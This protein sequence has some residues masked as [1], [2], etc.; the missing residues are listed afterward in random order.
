MSY[1]NYA[2]YA[3]T[4][5]AEFIK[6]MCS[7]EFQSLVDILDK[8]NVSLISFAEAVERDDFIGELT[9]SD[10]IEDEQVQE[11]LTLWESLVARFKIVTGGLELSLICHDSDAEGEDLEDGYSWVVYDVYQLT[12]AGKKF[13]DEITRKTWVVGG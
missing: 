2:C 7:K 12:P 4:V 9:C 5:S 6:K 1:R 11:I 8:Y 10:D 13:K 3:D